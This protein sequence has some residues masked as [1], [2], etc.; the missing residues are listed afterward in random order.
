MFWPNGHG[1]PV[2]GLHVWP[3][4]A[5]GARRRGRQARATLATRPSRCV[6]APLHAA[7][8]LR[9]TNAVIRPS[10][11]QSSIN[12]IS[13]S[14]VQDSD[15]CSVGARGGGLS[16]GGEDIN[17]RFSGRMAWGLGSA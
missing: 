4:L 11:H 1:V 3:T 15:I 6:R 10:G 7:L 2:Q 16:R 12:S 13:L 17:S 14:N 9:S 5:A 8:R